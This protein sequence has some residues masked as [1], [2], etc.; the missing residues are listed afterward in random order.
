MRSFK[1][2]RILCGLTKKKKIVLL[3][4]AGC[5]VVV[6]LLKGVRDGPKG[7]KF[8]YDPHVDTES[9]KDTL[10]KEKSGR[11][12]EDE[13][14][15]D[16][17]E[18]LYVDQK[19]EMNRRRENKILT[20]VS[21]EYEKDNESKGN[22]PTGQEEG[23][24]LTSDQDEGWRDKIEGHKGSVNEGKNT[25]LK[26]EE[27]VQQTLD[28]N[29]EATVTF[30]QD[31]E[32]PIGSS[33]NESVFHVNRRNKY[34]SHEDDRI[35][36]QVFIFVLMDWLHLTNSDG[37]DA[38]QSNC[39]PHHKYNQ[40]EGN[41]KLVNFFINDFPN[42]HK[43]YNVAAFFRRSAFTWDEPEFAKG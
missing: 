38:L 25:S 37:E 33:L 20:N 39:Q 16:N 17:A 40:V 4:L 11:G 23:I 30:G 41:L 1:I 7:D 27:T 29:A 8:A 24:D 34:P 12:N 15:K 21:E 9:D 32:M 5:F 14:G 18:K 19:L 10:E 35:A 2:R 43:I 6:L 31:E 36:Y 28:Q 42:S 26:N 22:D 3:F 13:N